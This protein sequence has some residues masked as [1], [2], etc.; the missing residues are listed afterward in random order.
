MTTNPDP[1]IRDSRCA[2]TASGLPADYLLPFATCYVYS[3]KGES[4]VSQRSRQLC[5]RAKSGSTKWLRS[6]AATVHQEVSHGQTFREFFADPGMLIPIPEYRPPGQAGFWA[7]RRLALA[8]QEMGLADEVWMGLKRVSSVE[9]SSC[10]WMWER[11]TVQQHYQSFT[12]VPSSKTAKN[13]LLIDDVI[14]KGRTLA[15]A[16]IRIQEA[17]PKAD[18]RAFALIRTMSFVLDVPRLF[19]PCQGVIHWNGEDAYRAP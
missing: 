7:A 6:Y 19:E 3:P 10:A 2:N 9:K 18:V 4:E 16:A 15:A 13:I 11:P 1:Q 17:F 8:L 14:T 12:V 5:A